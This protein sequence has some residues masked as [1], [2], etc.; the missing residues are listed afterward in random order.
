MITPK[1]KDHVLNELC[2]APLES[3]VNF[4]PSDL[5]LDICFDD[6]NAIL[7]QFKRL[8]FISELNSR[9]QIIHLVVHIEAHDFLSRGGFFAHEEILKANINKLGLE[10]EALS[11]ELEPKFAEKANIILTIAA[12]LTTTLG[13]FRF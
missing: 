13:L 3:M 1:L 4:K 10:L 5:E 11:K 8:G 12:N 9:R 2:S 6:L 7:C